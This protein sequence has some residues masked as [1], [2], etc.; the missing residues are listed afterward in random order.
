MS[1][2]FEHGEFQALRRD[3]GSLERPTR[4]GARQA[5]ERTARNVKD[6]WNEKLYTEGHASLTGRAITYDVGEGDFLHSFLAVDEESIRSSEL[7][8]EIGAKTGSGKQ[9]GV[10][11]LLENGA[12]A[13]GTAP[14]GYGAAALQENEADFEHGLDQAVADALRG[15]G[16]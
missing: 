13:R 5:I 15:A 4:K 8:A 14:H 12:P 3:L 6:A 9:A 2:P 10:V 11:R 1:E 16:L 7:V